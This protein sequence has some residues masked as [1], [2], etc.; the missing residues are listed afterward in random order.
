MVTRTLRLEW[1]EQPDMWL[2]MARGGGGGQAMS[3]S[4][5]E[6]GRCLSMWRDRRRLTEAHLLQRRRC[7]LL[8]VMEIADLVGS[9]QSTSNRRLDL[10]RD[11]LSH[12]WRFD[13]ST[14]KDLSWNLE[15]RLEIWLTSLRDSICK[16]MFK[17]HQIATNVTTWVTWSLIFSRIYSA[18]G[19]NL[20]PRPWPRRIIVHTKIYQV[21]LYFRLRKFSQ[22]FVK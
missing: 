4:T 13:F 9:R 10:N 8:H 20:T 1:T 17:L 22:H 3:T 5:S 2:T 14:Y 16:T 19:M 18:S 21:S 6:T 11:D 7:T 15:I 12:Q